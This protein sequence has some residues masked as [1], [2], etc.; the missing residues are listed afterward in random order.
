MYKRHTYYDVIRAEGRPCVRRY[1]PL[2]NIV[3]L[4][5]RCGG[6]EETEARWPWRGYLMPATEVFVRVTSS[7]V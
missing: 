5:A 3:R 7:A 4:G 2:L 1:A 6:M